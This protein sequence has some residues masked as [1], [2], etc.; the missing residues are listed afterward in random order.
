MMAEMKQNRTRT[1]SRGQILR[2]NSGRY[3][4]CF[5]GQCHHTIF[6]KVIAKMMM[7]IMTVMQIY[8]GP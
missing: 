8:E 4:A 3:F 1:I 5:D 7:M 6:G 2:Q